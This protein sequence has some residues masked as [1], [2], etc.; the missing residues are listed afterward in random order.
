LDLCLSAPLFVEKIVSSENLE[1]GSDSRALP[2][3][4]SSKKLGM[5]LFLIS[6]LVTFAALLISYVYLRIGTPDWP[7]PFKTGN[8]IFAGAMTVSL[9]ST[10]LTMLFAVRAAE[11]RDINRTL[12]WMLATM[13]GGVL[14]IALNSYEW[15]K[16]I[17]DQ[18]V[19]L[20]SNPWNVPLFG[21][22]FFSITGLHVVHVLIGVI[23]I[24]ILSIRVKRGRSTGDDLETCALYWY[25]LDL[26]WLLIFIMIYLFSME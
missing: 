11:R 5:W 4:I 14:F 21:A 13:V 7:A 17:R 9:L 25:F 3:A 19:S 15:L 18:Q 6:D 23:Y 26:V 2:Y 12:V 8:I 24:S 20:F 16:L 1:A 10:S 22:T